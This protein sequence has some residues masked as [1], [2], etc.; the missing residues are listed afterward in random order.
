MI[1]DDRMDEGERERESERER[2]NGN[3]R[4]HLLLSG[5]CGAQS[6]G[7]VDNEI[8]ICVATQRHPRVSCSM[9]HTA[10]IHTERISG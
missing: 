3:V 10:T 8:I 5:Q 4:V 7:I 6:T 2:E 9:A 1:Q